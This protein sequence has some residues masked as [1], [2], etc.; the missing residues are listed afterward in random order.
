MNNNKIAIV[1]AGAWGTAL[2]I[3]LAGAGRQV[4]LIS[5]NTFTP[6]DGVTAATNMEALRDCALCLLVVPAQATREALPQLAS[7]LPATTPVILCSKGLEIS[8]GLRQ[9]ELM[10]E[11]LPGQ[12]YGVLSGPNFAHEIAAGLPA[13]TVIAAPT[14][15]AAERYAALLSSPTFRPYAQDDVIGVELAGALKN[16]LAIGAGIIAGAGL[17]ENARAAMITRGLVEINRLGVALGARATT[18][19]GLAGIGDVLL[20]CGSASSRNFAYG[21]A[22]GSHDLPEGGKTVEGLPTTRAA[23]TLAEKH[24]IDMPITT[25][26]YK[27]LY[28]QAPLDDILQ[29]LF[30]RPLTQET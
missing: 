3:T 15:E 7:H 19:A 17:G 5:R 9:S 13:A 20:T 6:P 16:V 2:A 29:Q 30:A 25:S 18:F 26:L 10:A 14:M 24:N 28:K 1:G 23:Y 11:L 4:T 8:T 22:I 12:P 21:F 27:L